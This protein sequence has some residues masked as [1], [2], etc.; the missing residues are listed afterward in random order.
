MTR[1]GDVRDMKTAV[2]LMYADAYLRNDG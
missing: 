2:A 1:N